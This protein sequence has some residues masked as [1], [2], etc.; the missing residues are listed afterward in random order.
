MKK[1][2]LVGAAVA[3]TLTLGAC[4]SGKHHASAQ[5]QKDI[6]QAQTIVSGCIQKGN[7]I[8]HDGRQAILQCI[9]PPGHEQAFQDCAATQAAKTNFFTKQGRANYEQALAVCVENNR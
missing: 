3:L 6:Q 7:L 2:A 1:T 5:D 4:G 9:A 8:T